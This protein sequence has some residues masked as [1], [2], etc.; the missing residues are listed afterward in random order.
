VPLTKRAADAPAKK[1]SGMARSRGVFIGKVGDMDAISQGG[2][3]RSPE[4]QWK[5]ERRPLDRRPL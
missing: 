3:P 4:A 2:A 5:N 1:S